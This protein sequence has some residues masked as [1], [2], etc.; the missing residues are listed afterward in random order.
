MS[1]VIRLKRIGAKNRPI[2]RLVVVEKRSKRDGGNIE[3]VGFYNPLVKPPEIVVK[4]DRIENWLQKGAQL[5]Q[6]VRKILNDESS[7]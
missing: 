7:A 5:S 4:K 3:E 6:G 2:Y 1:V